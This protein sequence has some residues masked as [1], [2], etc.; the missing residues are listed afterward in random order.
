MTGP[1]RPNPSHKKIDPTQPES[2]IFDP[3]PSL[4]EP[5]VLHA[6]GKRVVLCGCRHDSTFGLFKM[7]FWSLDESMLHKIIIF[8]IEI[9]LDPTTNPS[10][11]LAVVD[12]G[13]FWPN[14]TKNWPDPGQNFLTQA[15]HLLKHHT[16][17]TLHAQYFKIFSWFWQKTA[18]LKYYS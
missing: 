3:H 13:I 2:K 11:L 9:R 12:L 7:K 14:P 15:H 10:I 18:M 1:I 8:F 17:L 4:C 16:R 5:M 6:T